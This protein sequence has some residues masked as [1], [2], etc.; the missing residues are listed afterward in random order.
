MAEAGFR[1]HRE[2]F[3]MV[4]PRYDVHGNRMNLFLAVRSSQEGGGAGAVSDFVEPFLFWF[5][6][7]VS[8]M[9]SCVR[10]LVPSWWLCFGRL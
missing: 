5:E 7:S 9:G 4:H 3:G 8:H 1:R 10:R 6:C 2:A